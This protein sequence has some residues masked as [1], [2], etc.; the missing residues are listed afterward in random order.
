M[1]VKSKGMAGFTF[2]PGSK[3]LSILSPGR[4]WVVDLSQLSKNIGYPP[5]FKRF[6]VYP[7]RLL[8]CHDSSL[9]R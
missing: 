6:H 9:D 2:L 5:H 4:I 8:V 1:K 3:P 7:F